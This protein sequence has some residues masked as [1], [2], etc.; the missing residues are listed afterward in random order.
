MSWLH[1]LG[2]LAVPVDVS[3][4]ERVQQAQ[5]PVLEWRLDVVPQ[6]ENSTSVQYS[7][8]AKHRELLYLGTSNRAGILML[9][10]RYATP[11]GRLTTEAP[12]QARPTVLNVGS[13][14]QLIAVDLSGEVYSWSV[15]IGEEEE[16]SP[17]KLRLQIPDSDRSV[18]HTL[19]WSVSL[20]IPVNTPIETDGESL[21][22][23]TNNDIVYALDLDG[24]ILWRFAHRVSPSR[25][26]NLQL[27]GAGRPLVEDTSIV[28]GFSDGAVLRL[29]KSDGTIVEKVYNGEGRYPDVI[30]Q[31]TSIQGGILISGFEEPS[32]KESQETVLWSKSFGAVQ[33]SLVDPNEGNKTLVYHAGS[34]GLLRKIDTTSGAVLWDWDSETSASLTEPVWLN[35]QLLI[36]SHVGGLYIIDPTTGEEIWRSRLEHRQTGYMQPPLVGECKIHVLSVKGFL[37]QYDTCIA[38][39]EV[40][41]NQKMSTILR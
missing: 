6:L 19:N 27:F 40:L 34:D 22:V 8:V 2:F 15:S 11:V 32:Y 25:K 38:A 39:K 26:G 41:V 36:A 1:T 37:E 7:G 9:D 18:D 21:F 33:G 35:D 5:L 13:T 31:P 3:E 28:V 4:T 12:V 23:S 30:A 10:H 16:V 14:T 20:D 29:T 24:N 17:D